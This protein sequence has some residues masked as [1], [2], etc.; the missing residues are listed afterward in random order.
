VALEF[1]FEGRTIC[2]IPVFVL[3]LLARKQGIPAEY[4]EYIENLDQSPDYVAT[5]H[6][7]S[8]PRESYINILQQTIQWQNLFPY[9]SCPSYLKEAIGSLWL[10]GKLTLGPISIQFKF[11]EFPET[12]YRYMRYRPDRIR[13]LLKDGKLFMPCPAMFN[14][15]FDCSLDESI[16][17]KFIESAMGSFSISRDNVLMFSHYGDNHKG[18]C[19]GFNTEKL[20]NSLKAMNNFTGADVR[21]VWYFPKMPELSL[22]TQPALCA[23]C[24][25]DI[26]SYEQEYRVFI[27]QGPLVASGV[28][29]FD[30][31]AIAEVICGCKATDDTVATCKSFTNDLRFCTRRKALQVPGLFGVKLHEIRW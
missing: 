16:R 15:P 14:D 25:H 23:T 9:L 20:I 29:P 22:D 5:N 17:L 26:W 8:R 30:R 12:I 6:Y 1:L 3:V 21:P 11:I 28:F 7:P 10:S 13:E 4:T 18:L 27:T 24:K 31:A 19:V 2:S